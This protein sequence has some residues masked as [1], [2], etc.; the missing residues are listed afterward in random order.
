VAKLRYQFYF[1]LLLLFS[2]YYPASLLPLPLSAAISLGS[3]ASLLLLP[4]SRCALHFDLRFSSALRHFTRRDCAQGRHGDLRLQ[5][6]CEIAISASAGERPCLLL[7][8]C[9]KAKVAILVRF[10]I[11]GGFVRF[12]FPASKYPDFIWS[13]TFMPLGQYPFGHGIAHFGHFL[14]TSAIY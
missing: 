7:H 12:Q 6:Q 10:K 4:L 3:C 2:G 5:R 8:Q 14:I 9:L 1:S 11:H 13:P